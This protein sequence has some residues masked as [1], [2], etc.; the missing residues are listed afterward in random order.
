[1]AGRDTGRPH[2]RK[3]IDESFEASLV[4]KR[5]RITKTANDGGYFDNPAETS[6]GILTEVKL[7]TS[8]LETLKL[9]IKQHVDLVDE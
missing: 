8:D 2:E 9:R 1:M 3:V 4:I 5:S 6:L 7:A